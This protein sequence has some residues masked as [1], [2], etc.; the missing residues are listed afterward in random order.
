MTVVI[1][2]A[3]VIQEYGRALVFFERG[4]GAFERRAVTTGVRTGDRVA[5]LSGL[6]PG[7]RIVVD[8]AVLLKGQ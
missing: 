1:P 2:A 3:A 5:I 8:G 6:Q 4:P 7:D